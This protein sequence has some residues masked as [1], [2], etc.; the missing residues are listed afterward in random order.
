MKVGMANPSFRLPYI[1]VLRVCVCKNLI[2]FCH[3]WST[4]KIYGVCTGFRGEGDWRKGEE[5]T[6]V[7]RALMSTT[8]G[9]CGLEP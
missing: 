6:G 2:P 5:A 3:V 8:E 9:V 1:Y 7:S 4:K